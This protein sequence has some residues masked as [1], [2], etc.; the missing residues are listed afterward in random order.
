MGTVDLFAI[1][2]FVRYLSNEYPT[3][4]IS[5]KYDYV[6]FILS[7]QIEPKFYHKNIEYYSVQATTYDTK[8]CI[9]RINDAFMTYLAYL[10]H[11]KVKL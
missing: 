4:K 8:E 2:D 11:M 6:Y 5:V 1:N 7:I 3:L 9:S 10:S